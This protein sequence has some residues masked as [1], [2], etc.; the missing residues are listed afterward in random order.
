MDTNAAPNGVPPPAATGKKGKGKKSTDPVNTS[1]QIEDAIAALEKT[2]AGDVEQEAES[3]DNE[4]PPMDRSSI[5]ST[6]NAR[7]S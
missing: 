5:S 1:K 2:K 6:T 3:P 7:L 4:E